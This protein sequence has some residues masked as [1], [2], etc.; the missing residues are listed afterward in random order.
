MTG[1]EMIPFEDDVLCKVKS[2][3]NQAVCLINRV[4]QLKDYLWK[5]QLK[6]SWSSA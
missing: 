2:T 3:I 4:D 1:Y 5:T 6:T